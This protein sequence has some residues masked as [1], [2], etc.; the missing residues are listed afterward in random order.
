MKFVFHL[1]I[2]FVSAAASIRDASSSESSLKKL[3]AV[4]RTETPVRST[5]KL[6]SESTSAK[7]APIDRNRDALMY[8][9]DD[10][11]TSIPKLEKFIEKDKDRIRHEQDESHRSKKKADKAEAP[12][13][14][15]LD[16][17]KK[18]EASASKFKMFLDIDENEEVKKRRDAKTPERK[19]QEKPDG[20]RSSA[21]KVKKRLSTSIDEGDKQP[22]KKKKSTSPKKAPIQYK[23][24]NQLLEGVF[25]VISGIQNPE[26]ADVR[27]KAQKMGARY[28]ADWDS[29]CT[30][31]MLVAKSGERILSI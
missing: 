25:L 31:L 15:K 23:P 2:F 12:T 8:D 3:T 26:R 30:H 11:N 4:G 9:D 20:S 7:K 10:I 5:A 16:K 13:T 21:S 18:M 27:D 14:P 6:S 1:L 29:S 19:A 22:P 24:F 28:K 17:S